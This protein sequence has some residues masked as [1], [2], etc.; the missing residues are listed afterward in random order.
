MLPRIIGDDDGGKESA[1]ALL[2]MSLVM[3]QKMKGNR[4]GISQELRRI[5]KESDCRRC[6]VTHL[7]GDD[8]GLFSCSAPTVERWDTACTTSGVRH[9]PPNVTDVKMSWL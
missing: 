5:R 7:P 8:P 9:C 3:R 4:K 1:D 6:L 2:E